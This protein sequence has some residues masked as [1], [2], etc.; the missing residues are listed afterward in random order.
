MVVED[1]LADIVAEISDNKFESKDNRFE[2]NI[3]SKTLI[4]DNMFDSNTVL[5]DNQ[6]GLKPS[7]MTSDINIKT[8]I[9][10]ADTGF[11]S[12]SPRSTSSEN[13][14]IGGQLQIMDSS[15]ISSRD[16]NILFVYHLLS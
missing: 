10:T 16:V 6:F 4:N 2:S 11:E 7:S 8:S 12:C 5:Y 3:E 1:L 9:L 13:S 15:F 14:D